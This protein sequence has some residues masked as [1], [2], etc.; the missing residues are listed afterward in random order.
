M[1]VIKT[2]ALYCDSCGRAEALF[3]HNGAT[4][5]Q[6]EKASAP[7]IKELGWEN[8]EDSLLCPSCTII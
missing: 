4:E 5:L 2:W 7:V 1:S 3:I 6:A 8:F